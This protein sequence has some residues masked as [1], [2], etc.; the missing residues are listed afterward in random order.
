MKLKIFFKN[1]KSPKSFGREPDRIGNKFSDIY[2]IA[3][4]TLM[5]MPRA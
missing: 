5:V 2:E 1:Y 4:V 3:A